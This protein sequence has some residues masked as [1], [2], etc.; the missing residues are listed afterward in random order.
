M[1]KGVIHKGCDFVKQ[2]VLRFSIFVCHD[3]NYSPIMSVKLVT[4]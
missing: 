4:R 1:R 3:H 2:D